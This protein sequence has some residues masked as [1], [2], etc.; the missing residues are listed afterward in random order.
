MGSSIGL[1]LSIDDVIEFTIG[2]SVFEPVFWVAF[3]V[4]WTAAE[5]CCADTDSLLVLLISSAYA[6]QYADDIESGVIT[7]DKIRI[8]IKQNDKA[9][10][11]LENW[12]LVSLDLKYIQ[13]EEPETKLLLDFLDQL[14]QKLM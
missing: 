3:E 1:F 10:L 8:T 9:C 2:F 13:Q 12:N 7:I 5:V 11:D 6:C 4:C 14:H